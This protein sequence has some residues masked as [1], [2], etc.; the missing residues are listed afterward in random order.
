M[1][2]VGVGAVTFNVDPSGAALSF[3]AP[4]ELGDVGDAGCLLQANVS[5]RA[6]MAAVTANR[7]PFMRRLLSAFVVSLPS[8]SNLRND[9]RVLRKAFVFFAKTF[10][11][12]VDQKRARKPSPP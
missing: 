7:D 12:F 6:A 2:D 3:G 5:A 8:F 11:F 10:V 1:G 9:L 4:F